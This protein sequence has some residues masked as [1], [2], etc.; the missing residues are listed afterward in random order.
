MKVNDG[1]KDLDAELAALRQAAER[2]TNGLRQMC[3]VQAAHTVM[4]QAIL[5]AATAPIEPEQELTQTLVQM[6]LALSEQTKVLAQI[7][8]AMTEPASTIETS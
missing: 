3:E 6:L 4:L 2:V 5:D 7:N 8:A 1:R